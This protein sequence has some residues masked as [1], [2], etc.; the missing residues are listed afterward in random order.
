MWGLAKEIQPV[1]TVYRV[2]RN[3]SCAV[4]Y[5]LGLWLLAGGHPLFAQADLCGSPIMTDKPSVKEWSMTTV[6][7]A[8]CVNP[9][10]PTPGPDLRMN[11][12]VPTVLADNV[13]NPGKFPLMLLLHGGGFTTGGYT[14]FQWPE[15]F[16]KRGMVV[17][18][19]EYRVGWDVNGDGVVTN[20]EHHDSVEDPCGGDYSTM[21]RAVIRA[22]ADVDAAMRY[23]LGDS[24]TYPI[25]RNA[26]Y[27]GGPSAG[28]ALA[29]H[30]A[31][32][33]PGELQSRWE[34]LYGN[35]PLVGDPCDMRWDP[36]MCQPM[37]GSAGFYQ[38]DYSYKGI[39]NCW[40][41]L[42]G[43]E[44]LD[45]HDGVDPGN[46]EPDDLAFIG[47][48]G[49]E[50]HVYPPGV[51]PA[52]ECPNYPIG[53]GGLE[54]FN[55]RR[56]YG[57]PA[58][59]YTDPTA[60][61]RH[62]WVQAG[63]PA[64][65]EL[66]NQRGIRAEFIAAR[67]C[68]FFKS[69]MCGHPCN[70]EEPMAMEEPSDWGKA[71]MEMFNEPLLPSGCYND[72]TMRFNPW[73]AL[74]EPLVYPNPSNGTVK[75]LGAGFPEGADYEIFDIHGSKVEEGRMKVEGNTIDL[76]ALPDGMY[77][78]RLTSPSNTYLARVVLQPWKV[79]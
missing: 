29:L 70:F 9:A 71:Y 49:G 72:G 14:M 75:I 3:R 59:L 30:V 53:Y 67:T 12:Y 16:V 25:D 57:Y 19:A 60:K 78:I 58:Q 13:P 18:T 28:G 6:Q 43:T 47:F 24:T 45:P 22:V 52:Y 11:V 32:S 21:M 65:P 63:L 77:M 15:A 20:D 26:L 51:G 31:F 76:K 56:Q 44:L 79:R 48:Y 68:C 46:S 7:V 34:T 8:Q 55:L 4:M 36:I 2:F 62:V 17:A 27:L 10:C 23:L 61:H 74:D 73:S 33:K 39:M 38:G 66:S 42:F 50:D 41:G 1:T 54:M 5:T 35:L 37:A 69:V 40:G 64:G